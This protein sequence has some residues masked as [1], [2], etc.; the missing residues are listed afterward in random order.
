MQGCQED[1]KKIQKENLIVVEGKTDR[2][3]IEAI[4]DSIGAHFRELVQ[5]F[6]L[7][8]KDNLSKLI[9][10]IRLTEGIKVKCVL[11][12]L[13]KDEDFNSTEQKAKNFLKN[14]TQK[15]PSIKV[16]HYIIIPPEDMEGEELEDYMMEILLQNDDKILRL[17]NCIEE[18][19]RKESLTPKKLGKKVFYTYL[20][21]N[22]DC[23]Y[24]G[25]SY[26]L[27]QIKGCINKIINKMHYIRN[28]IN[29]FLQKCI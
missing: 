1:R 9:N 11:L 6:E 23:N 4:I 25:T 27:P 14:L 5:I 24:Q 10:A 2:I 15:F 16:A 18:I 21:L 7:G 28:E 29:Q 26:S 20:L 8:G 13:D 19:Y 17:K 12:I 3:I 22:D